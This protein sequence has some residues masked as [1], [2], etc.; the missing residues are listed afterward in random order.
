MATFET[1]IQHGHDNWQQCRLMAIV[2]GDAPSEKPPSFRY[3]MMSQGDA[4][5][6]S[7]SEGRLWSAPS[8]K[9]PSS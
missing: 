7:F 6:S 4:Q 9:S 5:T 2:A 8:A 1:A 3:T